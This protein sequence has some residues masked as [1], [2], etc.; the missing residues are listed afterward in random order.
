VVNPYA[1]QLHLP[2]EAHKIR[3]LNDLFQSFVK[4]VTLLNQ[5]QRKQDKLGRL[6]TEVED[7]EIGVEIM[8]ESIVLKV[9]ELD[10]SLRQFF[11]RLKEYL[12]KQYKENIDKVD[13]SQREIRQALQLSK[14]QINRYLESLVELEY[15]SQSGFINKGFRYR[16]TYWDNYEGLRKRI[17]ENL[18]EQ[19][20]KIRG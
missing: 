5:Y 15:L 8:F 1:N 20:R 13:F 18:Q 16:I 17:K 4:M 7:V 12:K 19:L 2:R 3:R 10:G 9:D 11:E 14:S 6:I